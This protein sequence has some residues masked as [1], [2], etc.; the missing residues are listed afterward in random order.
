MSSEEQMTVDE[1]YKY[2][3][4]MQK[5]YREEAGEG[6]LHHTLPDGR[7]VPRHPAEFLAALWVR[8]GRLIAGS[9]WAPSLVC[10]AHDAPP[11]VTEHQRV[12][13]TS[14]RFL[15]GRT[16]MHIPNHILDAP[17]AKA[18][19]GSIS[20]LDDH[21]ERLLEQMPAVTTLSERVRFQL[22]ERLTGGL[23]TAE[24]VAQSLHMSVRT[25][26]RNLRQERVT[27]SE[28]PKQLRQ[29]QAA[30]YLANP[31]LSISEIAFLLGFSEISSLQEKGYAGNR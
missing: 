21:A 25:L 4:K 10:L 18:D 31:Q 9:N 15:S 13:Q 7:S 16:A 27:F 11:D 5:R 22:L 26:H 8:F 14:S 24:E 20:V 3:R 28:L 29:R 12:F 17:N 2:L 23:P 1:R 19:L 6:V 30:S